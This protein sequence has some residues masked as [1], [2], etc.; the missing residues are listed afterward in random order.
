MHQRIGTMVTMAQKA[1]L[2]P[3]FHPFLDGKPRDPTR[4]RNWKKFN[5]YFQE[6]TILEPGQRK[7]MKITNYKNNLAYEKVK[8]LL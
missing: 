4:R 6:E 1:G 7:K 3:N 5:K 2:M 8:H